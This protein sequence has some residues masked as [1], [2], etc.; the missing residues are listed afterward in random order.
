MRQSTEKIGNLLVKSEDWIDLVPDQEYKEVTVRLWGKGVTLRR[1]VTGSQIGGNRRL[2]VEPRQFIFSRIDARNGAFGLIPDELSGA[3]VS[4]D[5][6]SFTPRADRLL[7]EYLGW[8]SKTH[9]FIEACNKASEGTTNRK[10]LKEDRFYNIEIPLRP[11]PEQQRI[12]AKIENLTERIQK[13]RSLRHQSAEQAEAFH[14]SVLHQYFV[15]ESLSW[16]P[17]PMTKAIEIRAK[18][19]DPTLPE[20]AQLLH[21]SG[22]NM[23]SKTCRLLPCR[24]AEEDGVKSNNYLFEPDTIFYSKIRPYLRKAVLVDFPG[25]CSAD[26]YPI[27]VKTP[28]LDP[29]FVKWALVAEPFTDYANRLSGRTR[30]PKLNRKQLFG[31]CFTHPTLP[32]Q[33]CIVKHLDNMQAK[34]DGLRALQA[35]TGAELDALLP[36]ILDKAFKG[37]L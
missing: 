23:E 7:P 33:H 13:S 20:Y 26:I 17:M 30:M 35:Q 29:R 24:T 37:D 11:L 16:T 9:Q 3:V 36:S 4:N 31:F 15:V 27:R 6:P 32:E 25:V 1:I 12:V 14:L 2:R 22:E 21:V 28:K 19:V 5:F 10:R 18:Q 8:L 34:V